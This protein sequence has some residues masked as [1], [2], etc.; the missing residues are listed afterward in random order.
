VPRIRKIGEDLDYGHCIL[1]PVVAGGWRP[2]TVLV[3]QLW[4]DAGDG[5]TDFCNKIRHNRTF[6]QECHWPDSDLGQSQSINSSGSGKARQSVL[7]VFRRLY[8]AR[9]VDRVRPIASVFMRFL[10]RS[11]YLSCRE[12]VHRAFHPV[13]V[14][15]GA[16]RVDR[17]VVRRPWHE[18]VDTHSENRVRVG[19][20]Q[21]DGVQALNFKTNLVPYRSTSLAMNDVIASQVDVLCDQTTNSFPLIES[22]AVRGYAITSPKRHP[23]FPDIP[24]TA[25]IGLPQV[26]VTVWHGLYAPKGTPIE[27]LDKLNA[28]LQLALADSTVDARLAGL[29]TELFPADQRSREAHARKLASELERLREVV[30]KADVHID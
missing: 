27:I 30:Q 16:S 1:R 6:P 28:A 5:S 15:V 19:H 18:A 8:A 22:K 29:G 12:L 17:V 26:D 13:A 2:S 14:A 24:T 9:W 23:R 11:L 4:H 21:P 7:S 20:V 3:D 25:E 10:I